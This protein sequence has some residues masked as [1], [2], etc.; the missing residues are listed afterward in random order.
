MT[1]VKCDQ[2]G[3][4][5]TA[6]HIK[7]NYAKAMVGRHK[8]YVHGIRGKNYHRKDG[9]PTQPRK[10]VPVGNS[11]AENQTQP[12]SQPLATPNFCPCCGTSL[13]AITVAM[14]LRSKR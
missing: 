1:T 5:Y 11:P 8:N 4:T 7:A 9:L 3:C 2:K 6:T 10:P 12:D 13:R 14:N